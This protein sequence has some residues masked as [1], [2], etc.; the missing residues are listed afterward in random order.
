M[1]FP[2]E[3]SRIISSPD[4]TITSMRAKLSE[5]TRNDFYSNGD[6]WW[7]DPSKEDGLPYIRRDG[8]SNPENFTA[9]RHI[10]LQMVQDAELLYQDGSAS[11]IHKLNSMLR[12]F[13]IDPDTKMNPFLRFSQAI[14]GVC[15]GRSIGLI[16][17]LHLVD[18]PFLLIRMNEKGIAESDVYEGVSRWFS[19]YTGW[20]LTSDFGRKEGSEHNNH[21]IAYFVQLASFSMLS[22]DREQVQDEC[23]RFF[24]EQVIGKQMAADG[25]FPYELARTKPYSYSIFTFDLV[26]YLAQVL[27]KENLWEYEREGKSIRKGLGFLVPYIRDKA[28]WPY[29]ADVQH[30]DEL[31]VR[32]AFLLFASAAYGDEELRMLWEE[33]PAVHDI[34]AEVYRNCAVKLPELYF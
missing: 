34:K 4:P 25:S 18:I 31:P 19:E 1:L 20:L 12:T 26:C 24:K 22:P 10:M 8:M 2:A 29:G 13:F 7:P 23:I 15:P 28:S 14:P 17:T 21:S 5:G 6:Y 16:D 9:H 33:L 11:S 32:T 27:R 3:I 30:W